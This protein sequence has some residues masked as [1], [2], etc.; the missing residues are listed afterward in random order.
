MKLQKLTIHNIASIEDA[1]IDFESSPLNESEVFLITGKTGAGKS[2]ILDAICLA[3][4]ADTPRLDSTSMQGDINE[5]NQDIRINDPRQLMRR[6]TGEAFVRLT[7]KGSNGV[8]YE[9]RWSVARTHRKPD[10]K[11]QS[12]IWELKNLD[13][14]VTINKDNEIKKEIGLAVGLDFKQFCRTTLLAQ[15]EFTRFLNSQDSEKAEILEKITGVSVYSRIGARIYEITSEKRKLWDEALSAI[16]GIQTLSEEETAAKTEELAAVESDIKVLKEESDKENAIKQWITTD[17]RLSGDITEAEE[18][19]HRAQLD[20]QSEDFRTKES[21]VAQWK[22]TIDARSRLAAIKDA[23]ATVAK[24]NE[25][26]SRLSMQFES[27]SSGLAYEKHHI[28]KAESEIKDLDETFEKEKDK[29]PVYDKAQM[30]VAR[31][32]M[33]AEGVD[34]INKTHISLQ[35]ADKKMSESLLPALDAAARNEN[36]ALSEIAREEKEV[37]AAEKDLEEINLSDLRKRRDSTNDRLARIATAMLHLE[38]LAS[39]RERLKKLSESLDASLQAIGEKEKRVSEMQPRLKDAKENMDY[40]KSILEKQRDSIDKFARTMR[41]KLSV[42]DTCP[43]CRRIIEEALPGEEELSKFVKELND[44]FKSSEKKYDDLNNT[45]I[46]LKA[47]IKTDSESYARS[48]KSLDADRSVAEEEEKTAVA[49]RNCGLTDPDSFNTS[50]LEGMKARI[51]SEKSDI[52]KKIADGEA[53]EK[54]LKKSREQLDK[55]RKRAE[56]L[57]KTR[58]DAEKAFSDCKNEISTSEGLIDMKS[59]EV[60]DS[61]KTISGNITGCWNTDPIKNPREFA[62]ELSDS[63]AFHEKRKS[64]R[65]ELVS[66]LSEMRNNCRNVSEVIEDIVSIMPEWGAQKQKLRS[67][68]ITPTDDIIPVGGLQAKANALNSALTTSIELRKTAR[69]SAESN[70]KALQEFLDTD[71][72][73]DSTRLAELNEYSQDDIARLENDLAKIRNEVIAKQTILTSSKQHRHEHQE[74]KP[75][76]SDNEETPELIGERI[77]ILEK[78]INDANEKKAAINMELKKDTENKKRLGALISE[79]DSR[80]AM[81]EKWDRLNS[82][83]GDATGGKFR[84]IAQSYVLA[85]LIHSA[86]SYMRTLSERYTLKVRPGTFVI[87][88][89]DAYQGYTSRSASTLSGGESFLVSLSLALALSDIGNRMQVDTLFI[90]EGFGSLSGEPLQNAIS[91][92]KSLHSVAGRHVGIISHVEE[93]KERI[94]VQIQV[95]QEGNQSSSRISIV[96]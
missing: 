86:N 11:I 92:L 4:Y 43:V 95:N 41:A 35:N 89:E 73:L 33:M 93:L 56:K 87:M 26:I 2:T 75:E 38:S 55:L 57:T 84:K 71:A 8:N 32:N 10:R 1:E 46:S 70:R 34:L 94:P 83:I 15:G 90:D 88:L 20:M 7:F 60:A 96:S 25:T 45:Y 68:G 16:N 59:K 36:E 22:A 76:I 53:K 51:L 81:F 66:E 37:S 65:Q 5:V 52:E 31:L 29:A 3:L 61:E 30:L 42:G 28:E 49:C 79:T 19:L 50:I 14:D 91:T 13:S 78:K 17:I 80:K 85:S 23:E 67:A 77:A 12:K 72:S 58:T 47:E 40:A 24:Q 39:A 18:A 54:D 44:K 69:E 6:N 64:K 63:A 27:L 21:T 48:R 82:L 74:K 62:R 9:A